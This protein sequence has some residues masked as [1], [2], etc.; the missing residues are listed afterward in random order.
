MVGQQGGISQ[1]HALGFNYSDN[2][3]KKWKVTGSYFFNDAQNTTDSDL[4]RTF[5]STNGTGQVY[6]ES[7]FRSNRNDNHRLNARLEYTINT[8]NSLIITPRLSFQDNTAYSTVL[9]LNTLGT[10]KLNQTDNKNQSGN[11]GLNFGNSLLWRHRFAK[12]GRTISIGLNTSIN[13]RNGESSQLSTSQFFG[14]RTADSLQTIDQRT[15]TASHN[16][17]VS[18]NVSFTENIGRRGQLQ[19]NYTPS[20]TKNY[21][22]R[23][24]YNYNKATSEYSVPD[25]RLSNEF[26][27]TYITQRAGVGYRLR[28]KSTTIGSEINYQN[29][30]LQG[31]Q[32]YPNQFEVRRTFDNILPS[33]MIMYRGKDGRSFQ[34]F[35]RTN[36]NAPTITQL[37][38]VVNNNNPLFL[39]AGNP[40]LKQEYNHNF[41]TRYGLTN[42]QKGSS[43]FFNIAGSYIKNNISNATY[44]ATKDTTI[45]GFALR[46][47]SQFSQPV[48][49]NGNWNIRSFLTYGLP[50][51]A[52]K[53]NL[54]FNVGTGYTRTIGLINN[55][56]NTAN[57]RSI[58]GGL[59][60]SSNIS[61]R[62]DFT[63]STNAN[64]NA[65][66]NSLQ[67]A[68]DGTFYFQNTNFRINW[69]TKK[70]FFINSNVSNTFY[71]GLGQDFNLNF[72]LWN[73]SIGQKFLKNQAG[74]LKLS[75][76]DVLGQNN[77]ISRSITETYI[78]DLQTR[79]LTRYYL[80]T[81]T[82]TLRNFR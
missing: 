15:Y 23:D 47:G 46:T 63:L 26:D 29:A 53:S 31:N 16:Y 18:S 70:G 28:I 58:N 82:Y 59:V 79:V 38:N 52:L 3:G 50:V 4:A 74:E 30:I 62:L 65:V 51:K 56:Q 17:T 49:V 72:T 76:F 69:L 8:R 81:F 22:D 37:Q 11:N 35:Y 27:N 7:S 34:L 66:K 42:V 9:G 55:A 5:F 68:L 24:T 54:N 32:L 73:A 21:S 25:L 48:N 61:E 75:T 13:D 19:L 12:V 36:T 33:A 39:S 44:I 40:N 77:S 41:S 67:P 57:T 6:D 2:W 20:Y 14:R 43:F 64:Y 71:R 45:L 80:L 60:L 78:E 10:R 1:T